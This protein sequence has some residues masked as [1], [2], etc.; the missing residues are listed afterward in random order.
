MIFIILILYVLIGV[1]LSCI[2]LYRRLGLEGKD[3][4]VG[5]A[6]AIIGDIPYPDW[7]PSVLV[8]IFTIVS[9]VII[10]SISIYTWP[11]S[12]LFNIWKD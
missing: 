11:I 10:F 3:G 1:I 8:R 5:P 2:W 9:V 7:F 6:Y 12:L 4:I